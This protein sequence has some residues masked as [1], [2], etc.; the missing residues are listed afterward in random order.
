[1]ATAFKGQIC[2]AVCALIHKTGPLDKRL[3]SSLEGLGSMALPVSRGARTRR[4][5]LEKYIKLQRSLLGETV[6]TAV[7]FNSLVDRA[8]RG[9]P[10]QGDVEEEEEHEML[11]QSRRLFAKMRCWRRLGRGPWGMP[12]RGDCPLRWELGF[13]GKLGLRAF[14]H[15]L[16]LFPSLLSLFPVLRALPFYVAPR[17]PSVSFR[18]ASRRGASEV[19]IGVMLANGRG[20]EVA[21][22]GGELTSRPQPAL[23]PIR[24]EQRR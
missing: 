10:P 16:P 19:L 14:S 6:F 4:D 7:Q 17:A 8:G 23:H 21:P 3:H 13:A 15:S 9:T 22:A 24:Q 20:L 5:K 18:V 1:M 11:K 12:S 2:T